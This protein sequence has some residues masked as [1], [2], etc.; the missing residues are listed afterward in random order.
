MTL[1]HHPPTSCDSRYLEDNLCKDERPG[2][3]VG[4]LCVWEAMGRSYLIPNVGPDSLVET[5]VLL[6]QS[7]VTLGR[8]VYLS[9]AQLPRL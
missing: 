8:S 3:H 1:S 6:I 7:W 4:G 5:Q 9:E 2:Q